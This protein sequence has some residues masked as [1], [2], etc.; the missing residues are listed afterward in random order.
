[1]EV[2]VWLCSGPEPNL[3]CFFTP[4]LLLCCFLFCSVLPTDCLEQTFTNEDNLFILNIE[5]SIFLQEDW[6]CNI[7]NC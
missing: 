1:M 3:S 6:K 7:G 4:L 5:C 2:L